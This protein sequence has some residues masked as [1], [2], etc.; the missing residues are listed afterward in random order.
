MLAPDLRATGS[1]P[2]MDVNHVSGI[3]SPLPIAIAREII[4][5]WVLSTPSLICFVVKFLST[6]FLIPEISSSL[7]SI[8]GFLLINCAIGLT[9]GFPKVISPAAAFS[10]A[11]AVP[12][13]SCL[14]TLSA[15]KVA[16]SP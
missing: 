9:K 6:N 8:L 13:V 14:A 7:V 1:I 12:V 2:F 16:I 11:A 4:F 5:A 3:F 15:F 10:I